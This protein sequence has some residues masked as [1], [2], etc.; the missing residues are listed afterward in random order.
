[1]I[2]EIFDR[3]YQAGRAALNADLE[4]GFTRLGRAV[5]NAFDVLHRIQYSAPWHARAKR[6]RFN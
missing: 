2:D 3:Q 4:R 6:I 5:G 1:M